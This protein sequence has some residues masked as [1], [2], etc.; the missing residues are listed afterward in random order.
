MC[1]LILLFWYLGSFIARKWQTSVR[2]ISDFNW[3]AVYI[4]DSRFYQSDIVTH[5]FYFYWRMVVFF[6]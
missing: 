3:S 1:N 5:Y 2:L 6:H 4:G